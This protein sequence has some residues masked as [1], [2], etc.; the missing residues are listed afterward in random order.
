MK[1]RAI[2]VAALIINGPALAGNWVAESELGQDGAKVFVG[3]TAGRC[4]AQ[5]GERCFDVSAKPVDEHSVILVREGGWEA[6]AV[7]VPCVD[8]CADERA[9]LSC[10]DGTYSD[11]EGDRDGDGS[12]EVWCTRRAEVKRLRPD[13]AKAQAKADAEAARL[14]LETA[15]M[16]TARDCYIKHRDDAAVDG[17]A[18]PCQKALYEVLKEV[19]KVL[20]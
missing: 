4:E 11:F 6:P 12:L 3:P 13:P 18:L 5:K 8:D 7:E 15:V 14:V 1:L 16:D 2:F 20:K 19:V 17:D 9:A 10:P